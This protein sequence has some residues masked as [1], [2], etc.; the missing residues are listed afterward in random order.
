[1]K[2]QRRGSTFSARK[3]PRMDKLSPNERKQVKRI[4]NYNRE[5][6]HFTF[7]DVGAVVTNV[8][9]IIDISGVNQGDTQSTR[10]GDQIKVLL[11][12]INAHLV[13]STA[14]DIIRV[15]VF[16]WSNNSVPGAADV[17]Q[18]ISSTIAGYHSPYN[19]QNLRFIHPI[20]DR[21]FAI[22]PQI[23]VQTF[24]VRGGPQPYTVFN[25]GLLTGSNKI[26]MAVVK[27]GAGGSPTINYRGQLMYTD[28]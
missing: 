13:T 19:Q 15:C 21:T 28:S 4:V 26:Y 23:P 18:A 6:K 2:R 1:M 3:S 27:S 16:R 7:S 17:F 20:Y 24:K 9:N 12:E 25:T 8:W 5:K 22:A 14:D 10:D 11:T